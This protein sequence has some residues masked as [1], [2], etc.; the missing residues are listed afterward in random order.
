LRLRSLHIVRKKPFWVT[1]L[2]FRAQFAESSEVIRAHFA[3]AV[4]ILAIRSVFAEP[5]VVPNAINRFDLRR[6]VVEQTIRTNMQRRQQ[7]H[8]LGPIHLPAF[9]RHCIS[10]HFLLCA[11]SIIYDELAEGHLAQII[12]VESL[13][14]V[15]TLLT[16]TTNP[17]LANEVLVAFAVTI[18]TFRA[19]HALSLCKKFADEGITIRLIQLP[20]VR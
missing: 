10:C 5:A 2:A 1:F 18:G 4:P 11:C 3:L 15:R 17:V 14:C 19:A 12:N 16:H 8:S 7:R 20:L 6:I 9:L 13:A